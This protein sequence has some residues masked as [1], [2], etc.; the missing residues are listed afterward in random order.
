MKKN[1][2]RIILT[3]LIVVQMVFG[4][5]FAAMAA[6]D[7]NGDQ[8]NPDSV[9]PEILLINGPVF[10]VRAGQVNKIEV[11]IKNTSSFSVKS[12]VIR[13]T[14]P[15]INDTPFG[16]AFE[17][18][19]NKVSALSPRS[20]TIIKLAVNMDKTA[21]TKNYPVTLNYTYFNEYSAKFTGT[22]TIYLKV[23]NITA[24]PDFVLED[25]KLSPNNMK[26][27][28]VSHVSGY[29]T[30][31]GFISM[32]D[33]TI[34]L[35]GLDPEGIS[36]SS[37]MSSKHIS[38]VGA[39]S[40]ST[41]DFSI[42]AG[43]NMKSGN[44]PITFKLNYKDDSGKAYEKSQK[45]YISVSGASGK[46]PTLEIKNMNEPKGNYGVNRNFTIQFDLFNLGESEAKNIKV[47]AVGMGEG[48]VVP[49]SSSIK[50]FKSLK[51]G[52]S[53]HLSFI[54]AGT[55]AA[56]SQNYPV[57]FTVEYDNGGSTPTSFK[58]YAGVNITNP[59]AVDGKDGKDSK[60]SKPKIIVSDYKCNPLIVMAGKE[61]DLNLTLK[62]T[63][64]EKAVNN[65]KMFLTLSEETASDSVKTGNIFTPVDSSN[66][67]Y[68][69]SIPS[70][71]T[72]Q[73]ALRLFVVPDAQPKTY[74]L[75]VNFEYEDA[76]GNEYTAKE[77]LGIN[78]KQITQ[79]EIDDFAI[80]ETVEMG[81]P[82]S[83]SFGYFNTGKVTLN[84]LMIRIEGDVETA[85]KSTYI[86]N[87]ESGT[88]DYY[89]AE[90]TANK[91]GS[92]PVTIVITY[93]DPGG[94]PVEIKREFVVN[95]VEP[96][97]MDGEEGNDDQENAGNVIGKKEI[98]SIIAMVA[99][100]G[101]L[102]VIVIKKKKIQ[103]DDAFLAS[104]DEPTRKE[105][106]DANEHN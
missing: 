81:M 33:V 53:K 4:Q 104:D 65:I 14:F 25:I 62:N 43:S 17:D 52:E 88:S 2:W 5:V 72:V 23:N 20:E 41:F 51:P 8:T 98:I 75:T 105:G 42:V 84:N 99:I 54:F 50:D 100:V 39:A 21:G 94:E 102:V 76:A 68:F 93:D 7:E 106:M 85:N 27:G 69:D 46:K 32:H 1:I 29:I 16:I 83:V 73:K 56:K 31:N 30:N 89:E 28:D 64:K 74:T 57:E 47:S 95:V 60:T 71:G 6:I 66:T 96:A 49:K 86:G 79:L 91:L 13:P 63:H 77:L 11:K 87:L 12:L 101:A 3:V 97:P 40:S 26:P 44:Y 58:Q 59:L 35:D 34:S 80:P 55:A 70:K 90:F 22:D 61:F 103:S 19:T 10:D 9:V 18:G 48:A 15:D 37:G 78:V 92:E 36:V 82:V 45:Y 67:F 38:K 24:E